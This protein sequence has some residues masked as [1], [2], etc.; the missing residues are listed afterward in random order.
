[1]TS[2]TGEQVC[3]RFSLGEIQLA[4]GDFSDA[5]VIGKGGFGKVYKGLIDDGSLLVAVKRLASNSKQGEREFV[6]E[7]ETLSKLRHRN[8]VSLIGYCNEEGEMILVY[9]YMPNGTL[10][11]HL[12][13]NNDHPSSLS[14][15]E[16]LRICIGAGR[17]LD[18][19]HTGSS[20]IHRDVKPTNILLDENYTAKVSDFGLAK[21]LSVDN[22]ES[23]V[24]A[25]FKGSFGYFDPFYFISGRLTKA[26][27][28]YAFGVVLLEVLS[29]RPAID[30]KL[31]EGEPY[32][33]MW[34]Q[35]KIRKGKFQ[36]IVASTLREE[37]SDDCLKTF[38]GVV[39][40]CLHQEPKKRV[41]MTQAVAQLELAL[42]QQDRKGATRKSQFLAFWNRVV[43][44]SGDTQQDNNVV[45]VKMVGEDTIECK[46]SVDSV[47]ELEK[48]QNVREPIGGP[49]AFQLAE[50]K[51][52]TD[53]FGSR[54]WIANG[55]T[56]GSIFHGVLKSGQD[57]AIKRHYKNLPNQEFLEQVSVLSRLK[58][59]NVMELVGYC[60]DGGV[61]VL[62][63][64]FATRGSL[65]DI[66]H[67]RQAP[68]GLALEPGPALSWAKRVDIA[69]GAA[70]GLLCFHE[71]SLIH[72][73][74]KSSNVLL[75]DHEIAKITDSHLSD[76][77]PC[78]RDN[79]FYDTPG[80][81]CHNHPPEYPRFS[82]KGDVYNF[83]VVLL[84]LL[85]GRTSSIT[86][87]ERVVDLVTWATPMLGE[88]YVHNIV[89]ATLEGDYLH[90][91]VARM[92][93]VAALCVQGDADSRPNMDIVLKSLHIIQRETQD[94]LLKS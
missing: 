54:H 11:D 72:R 89:D 91:A 39:K 17:G 90:E 77:C 78:E 13:K 93:A 85:T 21:H 52:I 27:D 80:P 74:I 49:A 87:R 40:R 26:S 43:I 92:A 37:I 63:Y 6:T 3:R 48:E 47:D 79:I 30:G 1:M 16:R 64:E 2:S 75:F 7:L 62:V 68:T 25:S 36:Q 42:E 66:L 60:V 61:Q 55:I 84:E 88:H 82:Q 73:N 15:S 19:L 34:A 59:E 20:I 50:I 32:L 9:E 67:G 12:H 24:S 23:H 94:Y 5:H 31:G 4:T 22:L 57:A 69:V 28:T 53:D 51:D 46:E 70:K 56:G 35:D 76:K 14:W 8:L 10:A 71:N 29:G 45:E 83:G 58:H 18:Y 65:H 33:T 38:V 41:S 44:P 81:L 86:A